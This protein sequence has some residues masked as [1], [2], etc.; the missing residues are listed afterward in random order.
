MRQIR[1]GALVTLGYFARTSMAMTSLPPPVVPAGDELA[2]QVARLAAELAAQEGLLAMVTHE[3]RNP[4]HSLGL[5]LGAA[6]AS[7]ESGR[8]DEAG[9]RLAKAEQSLA[10]YTARATVL[11]EL[12]RSG[13]RRYPA[14][15]RP[16][17]LA[18]LL[19]DCLDGLRSQ[20]DYHGVALRPMLPAR[21]D[22]CT[23]PLALEQAVGNLVLNAI[24]HAHASRVEVSLQ[25]QGDGWVSI[26]VADDG[27]GLPPE[28]RE[29]LVGAGAAGVHPRAGKGSGLG[30]WI[31]REM[32]RALGGTIAV[33]AGTPSGSRFVLRV[34]LNLQS[35]S[36]ADDANP[37]ERPHP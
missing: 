4:L 2:A 23:D 5:Q 35:E 18:V 17:D 30:L 3:L 36:T 21:C 24:K 20:A 15:P 26:V 22:A 29:R 16:C 32:V 34:P 6:R 31:V 1:A 7:A 37:F 28:E 27:V 13:V 19:H 12:L 14:V 33:A 10:R 25:P 9:R 8:H 11:L